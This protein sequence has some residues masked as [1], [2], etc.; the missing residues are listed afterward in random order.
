[1]FSQNIYTRDFIKAKYFGITRFSTVA[2]VLPPW[3]LIMGLM[4]FLL[5]SAGR[6]I[7]R[8]RPPCQG[9]LHCSR[10]VHCLRI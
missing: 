4:L 8:A 1:M 6:S 9:R 3:M 7:A 10:S 2:Q 5:F